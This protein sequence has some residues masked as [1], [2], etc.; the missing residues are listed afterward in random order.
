MYRA[1]TLL[2]KKNGTFLLRAA[3]I[4]PGMTELAR[5]IPLGL[6]AWIH[7]CLDIGDVGSPC[8]SPSAVPGILVQSAS[9]PVSEYLT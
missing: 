5:G 4:S 7:Q 6:T 3:C 8:P 1:L 2:G 9:L